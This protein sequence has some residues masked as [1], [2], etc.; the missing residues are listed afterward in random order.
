MTHCRHILETTECYAPASRRRTRKWRPYAL[1]GRAEPRRSLRNVRQLSA[2]VRMTS[3]NSPVG[4]AGEVPGCFREASAGGIARTSYGSGAIHS[5]AQTPRTHHSGGNPGTGASPRL[6]GARALCTA[7]CH[8]NIE[9]RADH[10]HRNHTHRQVRS[11]AG[12]PGS[13]SLDHCSQQ[14]ARARTL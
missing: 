7:N 9:L 8:V 11:T 14:S 3:S 12:H 2:S 10:V 4:D 6:R 1:A 13:R 5:R